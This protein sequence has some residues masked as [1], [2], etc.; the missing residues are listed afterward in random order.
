MA[1][2]TRYVTAVVGAILIFGGV[3]LICGIFVTPNL[4]GYFQSYVHVAAIGTNNPLGVLLGLAAAVSS[5]LATLK[6]K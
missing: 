2:I 4:P 3:F 1:N 5:F 6:T